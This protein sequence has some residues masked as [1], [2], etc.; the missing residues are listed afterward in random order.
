MTDSFVPALTLESEKI[1]SEFTFI[2]M[3]ELV[4]KNMKKLRMNFLLQ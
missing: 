2:G 3:K 4:S 1:K